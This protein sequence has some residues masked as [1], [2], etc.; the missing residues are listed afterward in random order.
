MSALC[1]I[2]YILPVETILYFGVLMYTFKKNWLLFSLL[3]SF[4]FI[5]VQ[6]VYSYTADIY[7]ERVK[8]GTDGVTCDFERYEGGSQ[9]VGDAYP[10]F[11]PFNTNINS[12][13]KSN[14]NNPNNNYTPNNN[15]AQNNNYNYESVKQYQKT[16]VNDEVKKSIKEEKKYF[17]SKIFSLQAEVNTLKKD[18]KTL[19]NQN[20]EYER[21]FLYMIISLVIVFILTI[22]ALFK[23]NRNPYD[24]L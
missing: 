21:Y 17:E 22:M 1:N 8:Y 4:L 9:M 24:R 14:Q 11:S 20:S 6:S 7:K 19:K 12:N 5:T 16:L 23:S 3:F 10:K 2:C 13:S 15:Y 18:V